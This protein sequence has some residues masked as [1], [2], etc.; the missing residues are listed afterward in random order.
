MGTQT[1]DNARIKKDLRFDE[2]TNTVN[3]LNSWPYMALDNISEVTGYQYYSKDFCAPE[4]YSGPATAGTEQ[5]WVITD[6]G[7]AAIAIAESAQF[8][9]L[10]VDTS[11]TENDM[12]QMQMVGEPWRYVAGKRMGFMAKIR[13]SDA[14]DSEKFIGLSIID[15]SLIASEPSDGL[16][17]HGAE[18][19]TQLNF[20]AAK[21]SVRTKLSLITGTFTDGAYRVVGFVV[22][23]NGS[24]S[25]YDGLTIAGLALVGTIQSGL[26]SLP[27]DQ[28]L[29]LSIA[30]QTGNTG[31]ESID[32]DWITIFQERATTI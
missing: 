7:T 22:N 8:G 2:Q 5:G 26:S 9:R 27:N 6:N 31:V 20:S 25:V 18:T 24:V 12:T 23:R 28:D 4:D 17:F 11:G 21:G 1:F 19:E 15:T 16:Y 3:P 10:E 30:I 32:L 13:F 29:S 14:N